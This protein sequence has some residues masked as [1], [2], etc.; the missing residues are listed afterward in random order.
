M[1]PAYDLVYATIV[2]YNVPNNTLPVVVNSGYF[3]GEQLNK[4]IQ[5]G[6]SVE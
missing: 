5:S 1:Y 6:Y 4:Y 2:D 3:L